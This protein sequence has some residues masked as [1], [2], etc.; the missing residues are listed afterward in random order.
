MPSTCTSSA[1]ED[2]D[3]KYENSVA[4]VERISLAEGI[5]GSAL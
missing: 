1:S 2:P 4:I 3:R 5:G